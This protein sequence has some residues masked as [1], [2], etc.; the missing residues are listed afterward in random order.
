MDR[1]GVLLRWELFGF[2]ECR[3]EDSE[4]NEVV[5]SNDINDE[6]DRCKE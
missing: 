1:N 3:E 6:I 2:G 5:I 4:D